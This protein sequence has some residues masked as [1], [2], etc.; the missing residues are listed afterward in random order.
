MSGFVGAK[1][2]LEQMPSSLTSLLFDFRGCG[3]DVEERQDLRDMLPEGLSASSV[4]FWSWNLDKLALEW[5]QTILYIR[6]HQGASAELRPLCSFSFEQHF[7]FHL[8]QGSGW[9]HPKAQPRADGRVRESAKFLRDPRAHGWPGEKAAES[10]RI[11]PNPV[12]PR[13]SYGG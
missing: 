2:L 12:S 7:L 6:D 4:I 5:P 10:C 13:F 9:E 8:F 1:N 3:I 11:L